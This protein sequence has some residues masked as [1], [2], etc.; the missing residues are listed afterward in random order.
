MNHDIFISYSSKQKSIADGVCHYLEENGFKCWMAP[1][2]IT[3]GSEYGDLIEEA[4]KT[5]KVVVLVFSQAASISKWVKG[6]INVAFAEDKPILPFRVDDTEIKGGFRVMLN[7]MHWI[8]AFP[9]YSDRLPDLLNSVCSFLGRQPNKVSKDNERL[10]AERKAEGARRK[11]EQERLERERAK[12]Q[13][14][15]QKGIINKLMA[16]D[17]FR[18]SPKKAFWI[19]L[20]IVAV[21]GLVLLL[22]WPKNPQP[23]PESVFNGVSGSYNGHNYVDLGL[24][25]GTLWATCNVGA[26]KVEECGDYFAWGETKPKNNYSWSTYQYSNGEEWG[27]YTK[28]CSKSEDGYNGFID[29][30]STLQIGDDPAIANWGEGWRMPTN[31]H[32]D[33]LE[34]NTTKTWVIQN[35]VHGWRFTGA[36]GNSLFLP[37]AGSRYNDRYNHD[38]GAEVG[39][40]GWYWSRSLR[41]D[42]PDDA[43]YFMFTSEWADLSFAYATLTGRCTGMSVR[44]I[45]EN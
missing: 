28:Y 17:S 22:T 42:F 32:W 36:N 20:G 8:D 39:A 2:D 44:P 11:A 43:W 6:E 16:S 26:N 4:I 21:I 5:S 38:N 14:R 37:A 25:S 1:R 35:R 45:H 10:E 40:E 27:N 7:Q 31:E 30:L 19:S 12:T 24:P 13:H 18:S 15:T 34:K 29:N 3:V 33:E 23:V 9:Q 41:A